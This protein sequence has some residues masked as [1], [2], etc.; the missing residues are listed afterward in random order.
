M[1]LS[2]NLPKCNYPKAANINLHGLYSLPKHIESVDWN[3]AEEYRSAN[4]IPKSVKDLSKTQILQMAE[5][6]ARSFAKNE[7]MQRHLHHPKEKP[8]TLINIK[9]SDPFGTN[10]FGEWSTENIIYWIIR[11]FVLTNPSDPINKIGIQ[12]DLKK[13]SLATLDGYSNIIGGAYNTTLKTKEMPHRET[14]PFMEVV[15]AANKP[16]FE[17]VFQQ[18]HEAIAALKNQ[19][20]AFNEAL[21]NE[22]VGSHFLIASSPDLPKQDT[23]ELV[24]ASAETFETLGYEFM[25]VG[26]MNQW[27]GAACEMLNGIRVHFTPYR[28]EQRVP[29]TEDAMP[30]ERYSDDG[31]ISDKDSGAMFYLIKLNNPR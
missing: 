16:V 7:P 26:A 6:V 9:H 3:K 18:E 1:R 8:D 27:T 19:Y 25:V 2:K 28:L 5:M 17:L 29:K 22:K 15:F 12:E 11:L 4:F 31:Y 10:E 13:L 20:E 24:A 21:E 30:T 14:D 23:F